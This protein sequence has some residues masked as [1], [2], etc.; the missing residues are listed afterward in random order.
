[1]AEKTA[2]EGTVPRRCIARPTGERL[3]LKRNVFAEAHVCTGILIP[4]FPYLGEG[5]IVPCLVL[6]YGS[7][8]KD[9]VGTFFHRNQV[10]EVALVFGAQ[11]SG[12]QTGQVF[13]GQKLHGVNT[14]LKD[15]TD[16]KSFSVIA[17]IQRQLCGQPQPESI[18]FR[19]QKCAAELMRFDFDGLPDKTLRCDSFPTLRGTVAAYLQYNADAAQ[20]TCRKCGHISETMPIEPWGWDKYLAQGK[21]INRAC[22][23]MEEAALGALAWKK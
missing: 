7:A 3:P 5:A 17:V 11:G 21:A 8:D 22:Q 9:K 13:V 12:L 19:C 23:L 20:R 6:Q 1:M 18:F 4:L 14:F 2:A 16:P 10:D 15:P